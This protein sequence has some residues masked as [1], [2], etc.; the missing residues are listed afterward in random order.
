MAEVWH[1]PPQKSVQSEEKELHQR[2]KE[3]WKKKKEKK[4]KWNFGTSVHII[5]VRVSVCARAR[6][7]VPCILRAK[8]ERK[9]ERERERYER[10]ENKCARTRE[11]EREKERMNEWMNE[12]E[13]AR[14]KG[15]REMHKMNKRKSTR[16]AY[17]VNARN[18]AN[19]NKEKKKIE[20]EKPRMSTM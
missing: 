18:F 20:K 9:W 8:F 10:Q 4:K 7:C 17:S 5:F 16:R 1:P 2:W 3:T 15:Q 14:E 13:N 6:A 12:W 19:K 11:R